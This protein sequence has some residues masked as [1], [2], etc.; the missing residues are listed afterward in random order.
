M[1]VEQLL[2]GSFDAMLEA[3]PASARLRLLVVD[4][5]LRGKLVSHVAEEGSGQD[6]LGRIR[7]ER[8]VRPRPEGAKERGEPLHAIP[9]HWAWTTFGWV[10]DSRLG[11]MLD[12]AKNQ[13]APLSYL[14]NTNVQWFRFDLD[15]IAEMRMD[16]REA[17]EYR[18]H[19]G[20]LLIC[21]GGEPGRV[22][23]VDESVRHLVFQKALHRSRPLGGVAPMFL[24]VLP[25]ARSSSWSTRIGLHRLD[26][27]ASNG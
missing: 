1:T 6:L 7:S 12:R 22:A 14:R 8:S 23:I 21:E 4:L 26:H 19:P 27:S 16:E 20:D 2:L 10:T 11:K 15:D 24:A 9:A 5:G 25:L 18:L 3:P 13:G 17:E